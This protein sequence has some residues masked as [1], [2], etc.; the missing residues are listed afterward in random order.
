MDNSPCSAPS[1]RVQTGGPAASPCLVGQSA[2]RHRCRLVSVFDC[3]LEAAR[4]CCPRACERGTGERPGPFFICPCSTTRHTRLSRR[5]HSIR[6]PIH[7]HTLTAL[8]TQTIPRPVAS[9]KT[10]SGP[11]RSLVHARMRDPRCCALLLLLRLHLSAPLL[12]RH[13][14]TP[15]P[16]AST[17]ALHN[18]CF[19]SFSFFFYFLFVC[20]FF[21]LTWAAVRAQSTTDN[22]QLPH[23]S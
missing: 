2:V 1:A 13:A 8:R 20:C 21:L 22:T 3:G 18:F 11:T 7:P 23:S 17:R 6:I 15:P 4:R 10:A 14:H 12:L 5:S 9:P 19:F 16:C